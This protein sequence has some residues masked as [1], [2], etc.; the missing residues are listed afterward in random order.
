MTKLVV[1]P[2]NKFAVQTKLLDIIFGSKYKR[3]QVIQYI[4]QVC[5]T[6]RCPKKTNAED[7]LVNPVVS[8]INIDKS[9]D[10]LSLENKCE[11]SYLLYDHPAHA[12][13][14]ENSRGLQ[15]TK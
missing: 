11:C 8:R 6:M 13:A 15:L 10:L 3:K 14:N 2:L 4:C 1:D 7:V 9:L 12:M 5:A